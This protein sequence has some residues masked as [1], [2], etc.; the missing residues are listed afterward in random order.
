MKKMWAHISL[1]ECIVQIF[2][3]EKEARITLEELGWLGSLSEVRE[4]NVNDDPP[5]GDLD[6]LNEL[7]QTRWKENNI[8]ALRFSKGIKFY[9]QNIYDRY[10]LVYDSM[11]LDRIKNLPENTE[12]DSCL[13][14]DFEQREVEDFIKEKGNQ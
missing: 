5:S 10:K 4:I 11:D 14:E 8:K 6:E 12:L 2:E 13:N 3:T 7:I 9:E 1:D